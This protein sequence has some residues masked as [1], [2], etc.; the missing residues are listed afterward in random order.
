MA[1]KRVETVSEWKRVETVPE[2]DY[3]VTR[4][5]LGYTVELIQAQKDGSQKRA[6]VPL[7]DLAWGDANDVGKAMVEAL[8]QHTIMLDTEEDARRKIRYLRERRK[9][10]EAALAEVDADIEKERKRIK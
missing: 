8:A 1:A 10:A 2:W 3:T 9:A 5:D 4:S 7:L 6:E